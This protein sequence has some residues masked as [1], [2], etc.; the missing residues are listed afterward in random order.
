MKSSGNMP[1]SLLLMLLALVVLPACS[2]LPLAAS[3]LET[4]VA[5]TE[6]AGAATQVPASG[7]SSNISSANQDLLVT[8]EVPQADP[9]DLACRLQGKCNIPRTLPAPAR[10]YQ[11]GDRLQFWLMN[12]DTSENF[13]IWA[14]LK[15]IT[16]HSYFWL[17][18]GV[19]AKPAD[20]AAL[21]TA[22]EDHIYPTDRHFFGSEPTPGVDGDP[23]LYVLYVKGVGNSVGGYFSSA[24]AVNPAVR[25]YSNGYEGFVFNADGELLT[26]SYTY[27]TLAHE[28]QHMIHMG[29]DR[30]ETTSF[31]EGFS[32]LAGFL[33]GY[34]VGGADQLFA[35]NPDLPLMQWTSLSD[36]P[37]TTAAHYGA[38]FLFL[39]YFLDR[40]G[41]DA[42]QAVVRDPENGLRSMD[43]V[44]RSMNIIDP[45]TGSV[46]TANDVVMDWMTTLLV[47]NPSVG[48]GRF[49]YHNYRGAPTV[50]PDRVVSSCPADLNGTVNQYGAKYL[51][52]ECPGDFT[53]NFK[54]ATS[55]RVIDAS[56]H[57]GKYAFWSN[58]GD[59]SD[60]TLTRIFD[61]TKVSGPAEFSYWTWYDLEKGWDYAY[62]EASTDGQK[63]DILKTPSCFNE[64][65]SGNAY[66]CGYTGQ[67]GGGSGAQWVRESVD[68]SAYAGKQ[69]QLRFEYVTDAAL[70]GEG[71]LVDD[72]S[73]P[74]VGYS[75]DLETD[76]GGWQGNG[77]VRQDNIL[78]QTY[79][80][81]LITTTEAGTTIKAVPVNADQ[82]AQVAVRLA[83][84]DRAVLLLTATQVLTGLPAEY[85]VS[86]R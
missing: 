22:F 64:D 51:A 70:N 82:S 58:K 66:G 41:A 61:L 47:G 46:V 44:L 9:Y 48:D 10:P 39:T 59:E 40:F 29:L 16:P 69:V 21:M 4:L 5:P 17:Q 73:L 2:A 84:G 19:T 14:T 86:I 77:F 18:D 50:E 57:S 31:N 25:K 28:F 11:V 67:S 49:V 45:Q 52:L 37:R 54:G 63:W 34:D 15:Y 53:V 8:T 13:Q 32:E 71:F 78:P 36:D 56:A 80:L 30:N 75:A 42:T 38:S 7:P 76:D 79:L 74:A 65:K 6:I 3:A 35:L 72:L 1:Y 85:S 83:Q 43:E 23:H 68:L 55:T 24:D 81:R 62:L 27:S 60:M 26:D 12:Q 20:I 33:N